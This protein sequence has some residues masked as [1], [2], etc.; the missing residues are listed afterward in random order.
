MTRLADEEVVALLRAARS[1][2]DQVIVLLMA[3]AGLRRGEVAGLRRGD[4]HL[5]VDNI[6][7][8]CRISAAH[9]HVVPRDNSNGA[10]A[11][12]RLPRAVPLDHMVVRALD[13][14]AT[15]CGCGRGGS[16]W[17]RSR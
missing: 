14:Y 7:L 12:A 10:W 9:V 3:R 6:G 16:W 17:C 13:L 2:R 8:G 5:L 11:K 1:A 15:G 4:L